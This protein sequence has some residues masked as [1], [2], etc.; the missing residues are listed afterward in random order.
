MEEANEIEATVQALKTGIGAA[1]QQGPFAVPEGYFDSLAVDLAEG[2][3]AAGGEDRL[4]P[5]PK[6]SPFAVPDDYFEQLPQQLSAFARTA[7]RDRPKGR[8]IAL[9]A[10]R[11]QLMRLAAA[12]LVL[13][14]SLGSY[15]YYQLHTPDGKAAHQLAKLDPDTLGGYVLQHADE[16]DYETVETAVASSHT[17]VHAAVSTLDESDIEAYLNESGEAA[18]Q[19]YN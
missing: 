1:S 18:P 15:R 13:G 12:L 4:L 8:I 7:G 5:Y 10:L 17:D 19:H 2:A 3:V 16:F 9:P 6:Q 14:L 11:G